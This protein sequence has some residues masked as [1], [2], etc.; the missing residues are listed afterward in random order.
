MKAITYKGAVYVLAKA[1][2]TKPKGWTKKSM[3]SQWDSLGGT[4]TKCME[5]MKG[6]VTSPG[7]YCNSLRRA[8]GAK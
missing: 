8:V 5:K 6:H 3:R 2:E 7:A 4:V 1:W